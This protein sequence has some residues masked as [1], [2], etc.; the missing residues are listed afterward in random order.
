MVVAYKS[1]KSSKNSILPI[2][3]IVLFAQTYL[4]QAEGGF[5]LSWH[6]RAGI[7][8]ADQHSI[9]LQDSYA[10]AGT[11]RVWINHEW[12]ADLILGSTYQNLGSVGL[13]LLRGS[14]FV[15]IALLTFETLVLIYDARIFVALIVSAI[16][17]PVLGQFANLRPQTFSLLFLGAIILI[18][19][20][21]RFRRSLSIWLLP[22][23]F[24]IWVNTHGS[25]I[26]GMIVTLISI[27]SLLTNRDGNGA[28]SKGE[29]GELAV[30]L[31]LCGLAALVQPFGLD[32]FWYLDKEM[33]SSHAFIPE[34]RMLGGNQWWAFILFVV[35][36]LA[37]FIFSPKSGRYCNLVILL[38]T[39]ILTILHSRFLP[40]A[41]IF[42][43]VVFFESLAT[44]FDG[45]VCELNTFF[46]PIKR[47]RILLAI[48][49]LATV[50]AALRISVFGLQLVSAPNAIPAQALEF[51]KN[52]HVGSKLILPVQ[53]GGSAI[54]ALNPEYRVSIDGRNVS[55]YKSDYFDGYNKAF[56]NG[57]VKGVLELAPGDV[58]LVARGKKVETARRKD[59]AWK[60]LFEDE[61]AVVYGSA[62]A[63]S[64]EIK[65]SR[66]KDT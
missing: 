9:T 36:P 43:T 34:W 5:D 46:E 32:L 11:D 4:I 62:T 39:G 38:L 56:V 26:F 66:K 28:I 60:I 49:I 1:S 23:L 47:R 54:W 8:I 13:V 55:A 40:Y 27:A 37:S 41:A 24:V 61:D 63:N 29:R 30:V 6:L 64:L 14:L 18:F 45:S 51:L 20:R 10:F 65:G 15:S 59:A 44:R 35:L 53:W 21:Y 2:L 33:R 52:S 7:Q 42:G 25:F 58:W 48:A 3:L 22:P 17:N 57:N 50:P 31:I 12:L 16:I 19:E